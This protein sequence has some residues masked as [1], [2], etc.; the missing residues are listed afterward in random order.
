VGTSLGEKKLEESQWRSTLDRTVGFQIRSTK[1][2]EGSRLQVN[3]RGWEK[4]ALVENVVR[5]PK[6]GEATG[7]GCQ[8]WKKSGKPNWFYQEEKL[9]GKGKFA[10]KAGPRTE[11]GGPRQR[12]RKGKKTRRGG[13]SKKN[14]RKKTKG[15]KFRGEGDLDGAGVAQSLRGWGKEIELP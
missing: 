5:A 10:G 7:R 6:G 8:V 13:R 14:A 3:L 9:G 2:I 4:R 15:E 11:M 1:K 12:N